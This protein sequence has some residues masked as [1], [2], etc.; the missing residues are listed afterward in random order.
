[1]KEQNYSLSKLIKEKASTFKEWLS[2]EELFR[3]Y[4][5]LD[6]D[7]ISSSTIMI[8]L[9]KSQGKM[10]Q[11]TIIEQLS[12]EMI[13]D[14][15][16]NGGPVILLDFG[17]GQLDK[18]KKII[19]KR[20]IL[21]ID[22][23]QPQ[24]SLESKNLIHINPCL[25]GID[26]GTQVSASGVC[27]LFSKQFKQNSFNASIAIIGAQGDLQELNSSINSAIISESVLEQR[28][29][30]DVYGLNTRPIHKALEYATDLIPDVSG[31][32]TSTVNFLTELKIPLKDGDDWMTINELSSEEKQRLISNIIIKRSKL[33]NPEDIFHTVYE[34]EIGKKRSIS[35]WSAVLNACGRMN[36]PSMG[37]SALLNPSYE[38]KIDV[39]LKEY[40]KTIAEG[41]RW[42]ESNMKNADFIK[43]TDNALYFISK[44]MINYKIIGTLCSIKSMDLKKKFIVGFADN[45]DVTK[46]SVR[47][48]GHSELKACDLVINAVAGLGEGGGHAQAAGANIKKGC[49]L[50]FIKKFE[51][52]FKT[53]K[54][55]LN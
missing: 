27:Y 10:F 47:R 40:R 8:N 30:L 41:L 42:L 6:A 22:H 45:N 18:L 37:V 14:I 28:Q 26:G 12:K 51:K 11:L 48:S 7:G 52:A 32:E 25:A 3:V 5:H 35:E 46:V 2:K 29:D 55:L 53:E 1:M 36:M 13:K 54:G 17:S 33:E 49:E 15:K 43:E 24:G 23:H 19:S 16:A 31:D 21:I 4:S 20:K 39:V 44:E 9:L 50:D 34:L 38:N